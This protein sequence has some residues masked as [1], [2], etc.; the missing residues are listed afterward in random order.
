MYDLNAHLVFVPKDRRAVLTA[1]VFAALRAAWD[2]VCQDFESRLLEANYEPD[3]VHLLVAYP[4]KVS[5]ARLVNSL[6]GVSAR[7]LKALHFEE[8]TRML[9]GANFWSPSYCAVS[10]GGA[11]LDAVRRY[12]ES[13]RH[14]TPT[15]AA[16]PPRPEGRGS[17]RSKS[18]RSN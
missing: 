12:V 13:Q 5:L 18:E 6:K 8:V 4:P 14:P 2:T 9:C 10:C 16:A 3:H 15:V 11:S 7:R 1:R 17:L